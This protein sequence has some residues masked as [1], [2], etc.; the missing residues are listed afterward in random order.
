MQE[1]ERVM[2]FLHQRVFLKI[3]LGIVSMHNPV[4]MYV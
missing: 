1:K 2:A 4:E 3:I